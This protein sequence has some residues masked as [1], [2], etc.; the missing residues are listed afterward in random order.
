MHDKN[1]AVIGKNIKRFRKQNYYS[2]EKLAELLEISTNH[3]YRIEKAKSHISLQLLFKITDIFQI[4]VTE[5]LME[6]HEKNLILFKD[7]E[8]I[9]TKSSDM[10]KEIIYKTIHNLYITLRTVGI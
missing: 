8:K 10:E 1:Y 2:Q 7:L 5:L 4:E 9:W 3:L 6:E